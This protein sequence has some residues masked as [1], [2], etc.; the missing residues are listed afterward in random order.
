MADLIAEGRDPEHRLSLRLTEGAPAV[1][2]RG[3]GCF[4]VPW[5]PWLSRRHAEFRWEGEQLHVRKVPEATNPIYRRG[6]EFDQG[7][8]SPGEGF[9]IGETFF[10]L[11][12][13]D[14]SPSAEGRVILQSRTIRA[15]DLKQ[16][17]FRHAPHRIDVLN[18]LPDVISSAA[19]DR[20]LFNQL[21]NVLLAGIA[22]A[23]AVAI[24]DVGRPGEHD[25]VTVLYWDRR[26]DA[27]EFEPSRRLVR[28]ALLNEKE[29]VLHIWSSTQPDEGAQFTLTGT[30]DW[31]FCTPVRGATCAGWGIYVAGQFSKEEV[32]TVLGPWEACELAEDVKFTELVTAILSSLRE[33]R[34]LQRKQAV[35]SHF[36]SPSVL[37]VLTDTEPE[38]SLVPRV[39]EITV[40]FC[41]LR[42]FSHRAETEADELLALLRRISKAL[43]VMTENILHQ[44]GAVADFLGD[45]ALGFWGWPLEQ[46]D[47]VQQACL[48][49][50]DIRRYYARCS[51]EKGHPLEGFHA[52]IGVATGSAVAGSIG[53]EPQAKVTVF[54]PIVNLASRLEGMTKILRVPILLDEPTAEMARRVIPADQARCRRLA[55]VQPYGLETPLTV[56]ELLP[57]LW[58]DPVLKDA[59]LRDYEAA[60]DAFIHGDWS[61]AYELLHAIP[62]QDHGKDL[63][64]SFILQHDHSPPPNWNGVIPMS[65]KR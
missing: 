52:G 51:T 65:S 45:A 29:T 58:D 43:G 54:G 24:V 3:P 39:T 38:R 27:G 1:I 8:F 49:A 6:A 53:T 28:E 48:A 56:S 41:D 13:G 37:H 59:H 35:L 23:D 9:T 42:G 57:P 64:T 15:R 20:E 22:R 2:G 7:T 14:S 12:G 46:P 5:E 16:I 60:L 10:R 34:S 50:L 30:F 25:S 17:A 44:K 21:T 18:R 26:L 4:S 36:F 62:P 11:V 19:D 47:K 61:D 40:L 63:L 55:R 33:V 32:G 31:A